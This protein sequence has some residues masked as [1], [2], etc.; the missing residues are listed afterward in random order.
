MN[1]SQNEPVEASIGNSKDKLP[2]P[3]HISTLPPGSHRPFERGP[4]NCI[5]SN[6]AYMEA[7]IVLATIARTFEWQKIGLDGT[8]P[9]AGEIKYYG[10]GRE[11]KK[12]GEARK[13]EVWHIQNV[14]SV[15][16][17]GMKMRVKQ[18]AN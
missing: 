12:V 18:K 17:D 1:T 4:R 14:T 15:P 16:V 13:W 7:K 3:F 11:D 9:K 2:H 5:G 8:K 6:L 10:T